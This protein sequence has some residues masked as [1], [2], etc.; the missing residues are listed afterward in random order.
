M[1]PDQSAGVHAP[2]VTPPPFRL[3]VARRDAHRG[4]TWSA[5]FLGAVAA[6]MA[7]Y[8][9]PPLDMHGPLH[10]LGIMTPFCGGTRAARYAAQG[11]WALAWQYN[12]LGLFTVLTAGLLALRAGVGVLARRWINI[13]L[14]WTRRRRWIITVTALVLLVL[15]EVRQ[16]GRSEL[17]MQNTWALV[18]R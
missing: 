14:H 13:E 9:L 1:R 6:G 7:I 10:R 12:P 8:G 3:V 16:Q 15:L 4:I 5:L 2:T 18:G 11:E 17:L